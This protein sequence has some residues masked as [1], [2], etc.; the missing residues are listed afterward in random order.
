[1]SRLFRG[2]FIVWTVLRYGLDEL[3]LSSFE[4]PWIRLLT[5]V[6][7]V[8]RNLKAPRGERLR[9]ALE[10]LGPIFVKFGQ[11]MS[12]RRDLLPP[13]IADELARLQD[14]VPPFESSLAVAIIEKAF[15]KPIDRIFSTFDQTP[16]ASASIAQVHFATLPDGREVAVKVLRPSMKIAIEK[17]LALMKMMAG[18]VENAS[19]DGKRLKPREVV[20]E[21]DKYLHDELDLLREASNAA[22]L[23][24]NMEGLNLVMI[25][26]M[27]WDYCMPDV[28][29][30]QRMKGVP[31][32]HTQRLRDAGVD[33]QR[34]AREGVTIFFTQ[35][36]RDGFF[37]ADMHPGNI[38]VSL[39]PETFGRYISLDF[40][41]VGTLTEVDKEYLAQNFIAFFRR[42]YKRV[43]DLHIE[44]G[45]VPAN[46]RSDELEAAIR[47]CC[48]PYFD[49]PLKEISLGLVLMRL[50]QTSRRFHVEI[51]PQLVL[52][53]KTLLN[54]EGL[55][56]DLDP[57]LDLWSTA[58]PF[59]EKWMLEQVGPE[60]LLA[61]LKAEAPAYAKIL[62]GLPRLLARYLNS[63]GLLTRRDLEQLM[64]EQKRTNKLLQSLIYGGMGFVL[65]L[66]AMQLVMRVSIF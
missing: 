11:V 45:W 46:T 52:L 7:S 62:P 6:V 19:S 25:P 57:D 64:A 26:E 3:V 5:R 36:F 66:L 53:Q 54:I 51:Q 18:W 41:I 27:Y 32:S 60:K 31:I 48:E 23:R 21:F 63:P 28:M 12:T 33:M 9:E 59:L 10:S 1:M 16:V 24:R 38:Q 42:D 20:A 37:H 34:L 4:K 56:R 14:R 43:A 15:G 22:Q 49:R 55:G 29:V 61:Q 39:A 50:F 35:V 30:M 13:D 8:G 40:G 65:G 44:S 47:A 2:L 17:D 58:K